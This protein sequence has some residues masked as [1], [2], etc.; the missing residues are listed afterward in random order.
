MAHQT[1]SDKQYG[2]GTNYLCETQLINVVEEIQLAMDSVDLIL[3]AY[4]M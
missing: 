4:I 3:L 2:F 1:L